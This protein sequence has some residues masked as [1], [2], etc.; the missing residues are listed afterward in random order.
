MNASV[1]GNPTA[2]NQLE[3]DKPVKRTR[4]ELSSP[5]SPNLRRK[6]SNMGTNAD[7]LKAI[8]SMRKDFSSQLMELGSKID[9]FDNA[10]AEWKKEKQELLEKQAELE[11][12]L[13]RFERQDKRANIII[14]GLPVVNGPAVEVKAA[15]NELLQTKLKCAVQVVEA[16][17]IRNKAGRTKIIA[18]LQSSD[19]KRVVMMAKRDLPDQ[20]FISDDL[21]AKDQFVQ[22]KARELA[23]QLKKEGAVPKIGRGRVYVNGTERIWNEETQSFQQKN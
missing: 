3:A 12:R 7:I 19:D 6:K 4:D 18:K 17:Q 5:E 8:E 10:M 13:D 1:S 11:A 15:V 23:K 20:I 9:K 14:T 16:F 2:I 22:F 21:I